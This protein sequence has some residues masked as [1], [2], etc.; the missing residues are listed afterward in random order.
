LGL[1][2]HFKA[3][4]LAILAR[5]TTT[6]LREKLEMRC[7]LAAALLVGLVGQPGEA[8]AYTCND[9]HYVNVDG[10]VVHSPSCGREDEK[11]TADCR[12]GSVSFSKHHSGTC[13]GHGGVAHWD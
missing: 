9:R 12:D 2:V 11:R 1:K 8:F 3:S 10:Q 4:K 13:S 5:D 7:F 6:F